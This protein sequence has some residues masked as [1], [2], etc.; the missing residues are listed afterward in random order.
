MSEGDLP[1]LKRTGKSAASKRVRLAPEVRREQILDAA[2]IEFSSVGFEGATMDKIARRVGITKAGVYAHFKSKDDIFEALLLS[3]IFR[4]T[5]Q[6]HWQWREGASLEETV[7]DYLDHVYLHL[8]DPQVQATFRLL[9]SESGRA[10]E[11]TR[12]WHD[13]IFA[14]Y[15][16]QRQAEISA[17]VNKGL[18]PDNTFTRKFSLFSSPALLAMIGQLLTRGNAAKQEL[19]EIKQ[20]HREMLLILL[21]RPELPSSKGE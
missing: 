8:K 13:D 7:D 4:K 10:P 18:L 1:T 14:P 19:A 5:A 12:R 6:P 2:L 16:L 3:N 17:C 15:A 9:I 20:A 21:P 11:R